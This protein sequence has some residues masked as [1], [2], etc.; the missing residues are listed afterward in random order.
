[1]KLKKSIIRE[2]LNQKQP[3]NFS[4][5]KM[6]NYCLLTKRSKTSYKPYNL[7]RSIFRELLQFGII[8]GY[9]KA[10]W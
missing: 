1:M 9:K 2:I 4:K 8:P 6:I 3:R 5:T 7:P 10:V